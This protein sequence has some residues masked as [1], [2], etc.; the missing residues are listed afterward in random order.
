M[1][2]APIAPRTFLG[3]YTPGVPESYA[4]VRAFTA[5]TGVRPGVV[6]YYSGWMEPFQT[7]FAEV[8]AKHGAAPLVQ[9]NPTGI[10]L[11]A[12]ATGR[13]DAYLR[14]YR[15]RSEGLPAAG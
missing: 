10:S 9:I 1:A 4:G 12:I 14:S 3:V 2:A 15:L 11:T 5:T 13:Y 6:V 7:R 8:A